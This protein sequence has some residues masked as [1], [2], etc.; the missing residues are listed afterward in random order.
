MGKRFTISE[1]AA[2]K[3][4]AIAQKAGLPIAAIEFPRDG[5]IRILTNLDKPD[6]GDQDTRT[7]EPWT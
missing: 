4:I 2:M 3:A 1:A 6:D 7:P 5:A